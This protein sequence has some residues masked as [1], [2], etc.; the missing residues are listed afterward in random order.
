[1]LHNRNVAADDDVSPPPRNEGSH[2]RVLDDRFDI[3]IV[4]TVTYTFAVLASI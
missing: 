2:E 1:M 3:G 4:A